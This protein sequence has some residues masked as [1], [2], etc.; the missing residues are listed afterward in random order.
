MD[1]G[2]EKING[3][4]H[5]NSVTEHIVNPVEP[6]IEHQLP[7]ASPLPGASPS[8]VAHGA[9]PIAICGIGL[10][11]PG[12]LAAPEQLWEFLIDKGNARCRVPESRY[13]V[14]A[15]YSASGKA[16]TVATEY[17]Y[18]L[19]ESVDLG[20]LDTSFFTMARSEVEQ[21]DPQQRLMLE[22]ARE[23]FE[24]AGITGWRGRKIGCY[25]GNFGE[26]WS[27]MVGKETQPRGQYRIQGIGDYIV[28][29]RISY[30]MDL[31]GPWISRP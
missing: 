20:A 24:D 18:F 7:T 8:Q 19:H 25:V 9:M 22:V 1:H 23:C 13:N 6:G 16:G 4:D 29:N 27:D 11:L 17:G 12:G 31:Q 30:E 21:A 5:V 3:H 15:Y 10:R 28:S 2:C 14:S 26:D